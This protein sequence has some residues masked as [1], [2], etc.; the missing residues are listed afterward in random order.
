MG[1]MSRADAARYEEHLLVCPQCQKALAR[2]DAFIA[3]MRGTVED[4]E[5]ESTGRAASASG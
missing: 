2:F 3:A 4:L 1:G 5:P